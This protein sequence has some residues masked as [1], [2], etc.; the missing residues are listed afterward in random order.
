M[1]SN[2]ILPKI[3]LVIGVCLL[4]LIVKYQD[5]I[6]EKASFY[7]QNVRITFGN[8]LYKGSAEGERHR[9]FSLAKKEAEL[10]LY[11]GDPFRGFG[12]REWDVFWNI[13]YGGFPLEPAGKGLPNKMRQLTEEEIADKLQSIYPQPFDYY[14]PQHWKALFNII[15]ER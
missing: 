10:Q 14:K 3:F 12:V 13:I 4:L 7:V 8:S 1:R 6:K 9:P 5:L 15:S 11:M 2:R